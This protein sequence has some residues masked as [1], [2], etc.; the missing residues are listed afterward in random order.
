APHVS[1]QPEP[2]ATPSRRAAVITPTSLSPLMTQT[3]GERLRAMIAATSTMVSSEFTVAISGGGLGSTSLTDF[4][5]SLSAIRSAIDSLSTP[6]S[7]GSSCTYGGTTSFTT[8][9]AGKIVTGVPAE[10]VTR[11]P[12]S[13][14][15]VNRRTASSAFESSVT[16]GNCSAIC[17]ART[18][19]RYDAIVGTSTNP[20]GSVAV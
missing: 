4:S 16:T 9:D 7:D 18:L 14:W 1:A 2:R 6:A 8:C 17:S 19:Q 3:S 5:P 13:R 20:Q 15:V 10:S 12:G 11:S